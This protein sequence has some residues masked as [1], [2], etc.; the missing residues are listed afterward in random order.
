MSLSVRARPM[1]SLVFLWVVAVMTGCVRGF[2]RL[3]TLNNFLTAVSSQSFCQF[4]PTHPFFTL[5]SLQHY[6]FPS[7]WIPKEQRLGIVQDIPLCVGEVEE[8]EPSRLVLA[9]ETG[10]STNSQQEDKCTSTV[11]A[12]LVLCLPP[13]QETFIL[14]LGT[15]YF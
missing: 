9:I 6:K 10:G 14:I 4:A 11:T 3:G 13:N 12:R 2:N 5:I 8:E 7:L 15:F 1:V